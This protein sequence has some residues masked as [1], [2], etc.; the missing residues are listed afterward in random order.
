MNADTEREQWEADVAD[1]KAAVAD[2][3]SLDELV[4]VLDEMDGATLIGERPESEGAL[5]WIPTFAASQ[6]GDG[7]DGWEVISWDETRYLTIERD[8][9]QWSLSLRHLPDK[10]E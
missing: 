5:G 7:G 8:G 2:C 4:K 10:A 6:H 1:L 3:W 9:T